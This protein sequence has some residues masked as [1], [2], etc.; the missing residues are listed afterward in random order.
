MDNYHQER[1]ANI[2]ARL[3][4]NKEAELKARQKLMAARFDTVVGL[5]LIG[6]IAWIGYV[7]VILL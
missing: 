5:L 7:A 3:K 6:C 2:S 4:A 1:W